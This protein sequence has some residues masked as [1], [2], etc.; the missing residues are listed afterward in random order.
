MTAT[1]ILALVIQ[2]LQAAVAA[3]PLAEDLGVK[4]KAFITSLFTANI[5]TKEQQDAAHAH[6]DSICALAKAGIVPDHWKVEPDPV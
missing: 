3:A 6:V 1:A 2:G 5:I 4:A